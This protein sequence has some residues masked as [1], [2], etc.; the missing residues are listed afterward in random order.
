MSR[1]MAK[2]GE[3]VSMAKHGEAHVMHFACHADRA[4]CAMWFY[5]GFGLHWRALSTTLTENNAY[6]SVSM[7]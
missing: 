7:W 6:M 4:G 5:E 1:C 3:Q 2:H